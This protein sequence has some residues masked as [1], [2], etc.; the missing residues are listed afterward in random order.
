MVGA[1]ITLDRFAEMMLEQF[2]RIDKQFEKI[3]EKFEQIDKR[4]EKI[5][6]RI[7]QIDKRFEKVEGRLDTI[8]VTMA[9]K[10]DLKKLENR[11]DQKFDRMY[12]HHGAR[13]STLEEKVVTIKNSVNKQSDIKIAW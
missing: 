2:I 7:E 5:D 13:I 10:D 1:E 4:F 11:M 3:Y 9:T 12:Y 8:V 6:K